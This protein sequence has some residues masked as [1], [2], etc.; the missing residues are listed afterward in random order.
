MVKDSFA[1]HLRSY[2]FSFN[3]I[4]LGKNNASFAFA[5]E[6]FVIAECLMEEQDDFILMSK[7]DNLL[8]TENF[9]TD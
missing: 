3:Y 1:L 6:M 8:E 4:L 7:S 9:L 2:N 5:K